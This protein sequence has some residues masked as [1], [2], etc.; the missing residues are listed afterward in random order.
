MDGELKIIIGS[1]SKK[2]KDN[3]DYCAMLLNMICLKKSQCSLCEIFSYTTIDGTCCVCMS[4]QMFEQIREKITDIALHLKDDYEIVKKRMLVEDEP[5]KM[6]VHEQCIFVLKCLIIAKV[7]MCDKNKLTKCMRYIFG[8]YVYFLLKMHPLILLRD[9]DD[10]D[11]YNVD[12]VCG[13]KNVGLVYSIKINISHNDDKT[14]KVSV[15]INSFGKCTSGKIVVQRSL[16]IERITR[17]YILWKSSKLCS[18]IGKKI[19]WSIVRSN[20]AKVEIPIETRTKHDLIIDDYDFRDSFSEDIYEY[21]FKNSVKPF[22]LVWRDAFK[23]CFVKSNDIFNDFFREFDVFM[24]KRFSIWSVNCVK[25]GV[26]VRFGT[27]GM[28]VKC[29]TE[30]YEDRDMTLSN[31]FFSLFTVFN[32]ANYDRRFV[33][34][35]QLSKKY[36]TRGLNKKDVVSRMVNALLCEQSRLID[37]ATVT[38]LKK[39]NT[40]E[41]S[42]YCSKLFY[43]KVNCTE[44]KMRMYANNLFSALIVE[45][46]F[47]ADNCISVEREITLH[48]NEYYDFVFSINGDRIVVELDD[49]GHNYGNRKNIDIIKN[50]IC[51]EN[52]V[53]I[54]RI[55]IPKLVQYDS[56]LK[57]FVELKNKIKNYFNL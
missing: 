19:V 52:G 49:K 25:C 12:V 48:K 55:N 30:A 51:S 21:A 39:T 57:L 42:E 7:C 6:S 35:L 28:C 1:F 32:D 37:L 26:L 18:F 31:D 15:G 29:F 5:Q 33:N 24:T 45:D 20:Y 43:D 11:L 38:Y 47:F 41:Y 9:I 27:Y 44:I 2:K 4:P 22:Q 50:N 8:S 3:N 53:Q 56:I 36:L 34:A 16:P 54:Y 46:S 10:V 14:R 40:E 17:T 13:K 23:R